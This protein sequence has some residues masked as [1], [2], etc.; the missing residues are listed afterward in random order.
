MLRKDERKVQVF[1]GFIVHSF[2]RM[3]L[4]SISYTVIIGPKTQL[5]SHDPD[6]NMLQVGD[7]PHV[8]VYQRP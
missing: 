5:P 2:A 6:H 1:T 8:V 7:H 3:I 4:L